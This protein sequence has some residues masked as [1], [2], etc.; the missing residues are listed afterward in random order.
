MALFGCLR[1]NCTVYGP[2]LTTP[3]G[4]MRLGGSAP[5][6]CEVFSERYCLKLATTSSAVIVLPL[7]NLTP[8]RIW[9]V[10]TVRSWFGFQLG[11]SDGF[12]W[13]ALFVKVRNSPEKP[14]RASE[15]ASRSR[16]GSRPDVNAVRPT[17]M[18]PPILAGAMVAPNA[19]AVS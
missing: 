14:V 12:T 19:G 1:R 15:P 5:T 10:Q 4:P 8:L 2:V 6:A 11:A 17:R 3:S 16:Y 9:N 7:W 18:V 13:S